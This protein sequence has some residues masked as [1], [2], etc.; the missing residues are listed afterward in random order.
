MISIVSKPV[1]FLTMNN[2]QLSKRYSE[3]NFNLGSFCC[4][5]ISSESFFS[6]LLI[7]IS[8]VE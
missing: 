1:T 4:V 5:I 8:S 2:P 7:N 3:I 6:S